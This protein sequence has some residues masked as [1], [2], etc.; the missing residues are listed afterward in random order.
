[1]A[2]ID[3]S[4]LMSTAAE[5]AMS[6]APTVDFLQAAAPAISTVPAGAMAGLAGTLA[7]EGKDVAAQLMPN[8]MAPNVASTAGLAGGFAG[9]PAS[10]GISTT[11]TPP[12]SDAAKM[13]STSNPLYDPSW[14]PEAPGMFDGLKQYGTDT[15]KFFNDNSKGLEAGGK[16]AGGL[17]GTYSAMQNSKLAKEQLGMMKDN[18]AY[19]RSRQAAG[20][21]SL[22]EA[23]DRVFG[24]RTA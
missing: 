15:L 7:E 17:A 21:K 14:K 22:Q 5:T 2:F 9:S 3:P 13:M 1:M 4:T 16:L 24:T 12:L 11:V 6:F 8:L 10:Y 20:D 18:T 23:S 19:N